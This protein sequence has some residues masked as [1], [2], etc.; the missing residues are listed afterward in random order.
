MTYFENHP[1]RGAFVSHW[2]NTLTDLIADQ[3]EEMLRAADIMV[4]SRAVSIMLIVGERGEISAADIAQVLHQPHQLVTQRV[5]L[6]LK[7]GLLERAVDPQDRRRKTLLLTSVG[8]EQ[9]VRL[10]E[11]LEQ[12]SAALAALFTEIECDLAEISKKAAEAL[13]RSSLL[14]RVEVL[15]VETSKSPKNQTHGAVQ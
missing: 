6:L 7:L 14:D 2:L 8:S 3:G 10:V 5:D 4:P 1:L 15:A 13:G 11:R 9:L 12:A